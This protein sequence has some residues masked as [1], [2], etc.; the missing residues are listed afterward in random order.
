MRIQTDAATTKTVSQGTAAKTTSTTGSTDFQAIYSSKVQELW[1][2]F[3]ETGLT[4]AEQELKK[5]GGEDAVRLKKEIEKRRKESQSSQTVQT[6]TIHK[7]MPDGSL[8]TIT[9]KS[10]NVVLLIRKP[11]H[12][13]D[14]PDMAHSRSKILT[15]AATTKVKMK[16][17]PKRNLLED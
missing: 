5:A 4:A 2:N 9:T 7:Y 16:Q 17:V 8:L 15:G 12:M 11:P 1:Q 6:E 13:I 3:A 10:G 14:F